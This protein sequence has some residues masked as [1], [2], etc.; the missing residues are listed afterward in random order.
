MAT[1]N[2][3]EFGRTDPTGS[4]ADRHTPKVQED[5]H[6][7]QL[8]YNTASLCW[9][10]ARQ[11]LTLPLPKTPSNGLRREGG[12]LKVTKHPGTMKHHTL[13]HR[14]HNYINTDTWYCHPEYTH[15]ATSNTH[16]YSPT[17]GSRRPDTWQRK[18]RS[19]VARS[20]GIPPGEKPPQS[21]PVTSVPRPCRKGSRWSQQQS[22]THT[23]C[24]CSPTA[25]VLTSV[26]RAAV[27]NC[28]WDWGA[29]CGPGVSPKVHTSTVMGLG[30][31][32]PDS[33]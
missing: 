21:H 22:H 15:T 20:R 14:N 17:G 3:S 8:F 18:A 23:Q 19:G 25:T 6:T 32:L 11:P 4:L 29:P 27:E 1:P 24:H 26:P 10:A 13:L 12:P 28:P 33:G 9:G 31:S 30:H 16:S 5:K 7:C 2:T